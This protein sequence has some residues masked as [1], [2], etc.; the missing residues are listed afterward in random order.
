MKFYNCTL[1]SKQFKTKQHLNQ[2]KNKKKS[3]VDISNN[4]ILHEKLILKSLMEDPG[5]ATTPETSPEFLYSDD[6]SSKNVIYLENY[7]I[8]KIK[9]DVKTDKNNESVETIESESDCDE[10]D[11]SDSIV[12]PS[13]KDIRENTFYEAK[14]D[15]YKNEIINTENSLLNKQ[16]VIQFLKTFNSITNLM[17]FQ[18]NT[19]K[20]INRIKQ[21]ETE[22]K[23]LKKKLQHIFNT[24]NTKNMKYKQNK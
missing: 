14:Y 17:D 24:I 16:S 5:N 20:Y 7:E 10:N 15:K 12:A 1:C 18:N 8:D 19:S 13:I 21:L 11:E 23:I 4:I 3:C 2:H 9:C 22:N 6:E